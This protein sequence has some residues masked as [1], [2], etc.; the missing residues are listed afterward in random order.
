MSSNEKEGPNIVKQA[1]RIGLGIDVA[2]IPLFGAA[3]VIAGEILWRTT[4]EGY[5]AIRGLP[6]KLS[7]QLSEQ[8]PPAHAHR[9]ASS[10][11]AQ[12]LAT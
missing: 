6:D 4:V 8:F 2:M 3:P 1:R 5:N 10:R 9:G 12:L 7:R 11:E